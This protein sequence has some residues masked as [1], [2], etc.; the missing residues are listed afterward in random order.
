MFGLSFELNKN[1]LFMLSFG[2]NNSFCS[3]F[4]LGRTIG[5]SL[6]LGRTVCSDLPCIPGYEIVVCK[7]ISFSDFLCNW[8]CA[9]PSVKKVN[10]GLF[11]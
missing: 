10:H 4:H 7:P 11:Q 9:V 2:Q 5:S 3:G 6:H 8:T 1:I